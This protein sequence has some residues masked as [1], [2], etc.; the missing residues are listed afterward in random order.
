MYQGIIFHVAA[1]IAFII[2]S[3]AVHFFLGRSMDSE[4]YGIVGTII[5]VINLEYLL[6]NNGVRQAIS[7]SISL[8][9]YKK[10]DVALKGVTI[11][12]I[13]ILLISS[14]I[15]IFGKFISNFLGDSNLYKNLLITLPIIFFMGVYFS[16]L[17]I[18]N[19]QKKFKTESIILIIYPILKL[20]VIP[21]SK[22]LPDSIVGVEIGFATAG[23]L[24]VIICAVVVISNLL[25]N[26][27]NNKRISWGKIVK[28]SFS[29]SMIFITASVIMNIDLLFVK[30][31]IPDSSYSGYYTGAINFAKIPYFLLTAVFLVVLPVISSLYANHK[32]D[33]LVKKVSALFDLIFA[34]ILPISTI[35]S[36]SSGTLLRTFYNKSEYTKGTVATSLLVFSTFFL[37]LTIVENMI[38]SA[39]EHKKFTL[40]LSIG[41]LIGDVILCY[42]LTYH[43][44]ISGAALSGLI[45]NFMACFISMFFLRKKIG[46]FLSLNVLKALIINIGLFV[47]TFVINIFLGSRMNLFM[48]IGFYGFL[49]I[50]NILVLFVIKVLD[51]K[52]ILQFIKSRE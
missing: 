15:V 4:V 11:Q 12:G 33:E 30:A 3:Y 37:G 46:G 50:A 40:I 26:D 22:F 16:L 20:I 17:G 49:Y 9:E 18:I 34:L 36:A 48:V 25:K 2:G 41:M 19:G 45:I 6:L 38:I 5:T 35:I 52:T 27:S 28:S 23:F 8:N 10:R 24:I 44:S 43:L 32:M 1:K 29:Y 47:I 7:N 21:F 42:I 39:I 14:V 13:L 51:K 31:L